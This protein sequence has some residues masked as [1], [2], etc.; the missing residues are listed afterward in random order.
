MF[1]S[2]DPSAPLKDGCQWLYFIG[3]SFP[4]LKVPAVVKIGISANVKQRLSA[5]RTSNCRNLQLIYCRQVPTASSVE[6]WV[7]DRFFSKHIR[8][9]WFEVTLED[10]MWCADLVIENEINVES[11]N[12]Y[13]PLVCIGELKDPKN[14]TGQITWHPVAVPEWLTLDPFWLGGRSVSIVSLGYSWDYAIGSVSGRVEKKPN[15][16]KSRGVHIDTG[17]ASWS[18]STLR[19]HIH[20]GEY[21]YND[22][23]LKSTREGIMRGQLS[24]LS[25]TPLKEFKRQ[26]YDDHM[27]RDRN[28]ILAGAQNVATS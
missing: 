23:P 9:E 24:Q 18:A 14:L 17:H 5:I 25:K 7:H 11:E 16:E 4:G 6:K 13:G 20:A 15:G 21:S 28:K 2:C 27:Y 1:L 19:T 3:E 10:I 8:G 22:P 26:G 12:Y